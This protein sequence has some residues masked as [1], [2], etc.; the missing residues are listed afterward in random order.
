MCFRVGRSPQP[1][2][3]TFLSARRSEGAVSGLK[4]QRAEGVADVDL[5][6]ETPCVRRRCLSLR[7]CVGVLEVILE[8]GR[9]LLSGIDHQLLI[10]CP[11]AVGPAIGQPEPITERE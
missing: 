10:Q 2:G 9:H 6:A 7:Q 4:E 3:R 11:D 8:D 5:Y 1:V